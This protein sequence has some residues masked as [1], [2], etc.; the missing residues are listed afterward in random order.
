MRKRKKVKVIIDTN[1]WISFIISNRFDH[2]EALLASGKVR[3]LFSMDLVAE[4]QETIRKPKL[5]KFFTGYAIEEMLITLEPYVDF[6]D[7]GRS[8][9]ICRDP[10]D[11][12]LLD[13]ARDGHADYL[14]TGDKD[15]LVLRKFGK[16]KITTFSEFLKKM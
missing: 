16:T 1:L 8:A 2:L 13:L 15:I 10:E 14:L 9:K 12:F 5:K 7:A 6:I 11:D 3:L 4:V